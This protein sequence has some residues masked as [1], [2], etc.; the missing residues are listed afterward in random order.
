[1]NQ[2]DYL[3]YPG[4]CLVCIIVGAGAGDH[5]LG[6]SWEYHWPVSGSTKGNWKN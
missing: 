4:H 6:Q 1:M 5:A 2:C 3:I